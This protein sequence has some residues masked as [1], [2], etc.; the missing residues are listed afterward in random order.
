MSSHISHFSE[1]ESGK[2]MKELSSP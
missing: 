1:L 2:E